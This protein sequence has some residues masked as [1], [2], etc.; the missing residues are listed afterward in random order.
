VDEIGAIL[1]VNKT[2]EKFYVRKKKKDKGKN[3]SCNNIK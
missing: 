1:L 3:V 2:N